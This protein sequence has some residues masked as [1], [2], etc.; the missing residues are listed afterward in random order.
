MS[1][2]ETPKQT[3]EMNTLPRRSQD[4]FVSC[5]QVN[6]VLVRKLTPEKKKGGKKL[7]SM[8]NG[9]KGAGF[10]PSQLG[11]IAG[12]IRIHTL[13]LPLFVLPHQLLLLIVA[14]NS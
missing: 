5:Y 7:I 6:A 12:S 10:V 2:A 8:I 11:L 14:I 4:E 9:R 3:E 13:L 1:R